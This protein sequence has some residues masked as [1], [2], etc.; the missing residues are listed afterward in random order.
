MP[1]D[2]PFIAAHKYTTTTSGWRKYFLL[3]PPEDSTELGEIRCQKESRLVE[4]IA[5]VLST[6]E[7]EERVE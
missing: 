7:G 4:L 3:P 2:G 6:R 5:V 1:I